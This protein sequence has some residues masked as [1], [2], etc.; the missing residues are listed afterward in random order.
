MDGKTQDDK[1]HTL[2]LSIEI[3]TNLPV[4][5]KRTIMSADKYIGNYEHRLFVNNI[6]IK[7]IDDLDEI[8]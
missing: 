4:F 1:Y 3:E 8:G 6:R 2:P 5:E 7:N